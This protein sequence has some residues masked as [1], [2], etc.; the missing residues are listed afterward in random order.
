M[1]RD[2]NFW[3]YI[4]TNQLGTTSVLTCYKT[5]KIERFDS[6]TS[7]SLSLRPS[8]L[9]R[10]SP[11]APFS[12]PKAFGARNDRIYVYCVRKNLADVAILIFMPEFRYPCHPCNPCL[13]P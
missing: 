5:G 13:M 4:V 8:R 2:Y 3:V 7:R 6:L 10:A 12:T 1:P 11:A 9:C